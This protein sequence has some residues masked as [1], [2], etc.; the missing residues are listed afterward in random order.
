MVINLTLIVFKVLL[1]IYGLMRGLAL[2][3]SLVS[4][5]LLNLHLLLWQTGILGVTNFFKG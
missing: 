3:N 1:L 2:D 4:I 5:F